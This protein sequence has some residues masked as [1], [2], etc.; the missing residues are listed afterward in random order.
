LSDVKVEKAKGFIE[1]ST[2]I[3]MKR[4][5]IPGFSIAVVREGEVIYAEG[6]GVR[7]LKK[8]LPATPDTLYGIG[9][10]TKSFTAMAIMQLVEKGKIGLDDPVD[11]YVPLK[12]GS[13]SKPIT[14]HHLLTHSSGIPNLH[15]P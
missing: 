3:F 12:I 13:S 2:T 4:G 7:D 11:R 14:I 1:K 8:N 5:Q 15:P 9:S 10:C 6:F